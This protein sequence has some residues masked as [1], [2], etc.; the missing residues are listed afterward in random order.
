MIPPLRCNV[1]RMQG[2]ARWG[3]VDRITVIGRRLPVEPGQRGSHGAFDAPYP[4]GGPPFRMAHI[5][6][7]PS[8]NCSENIWYGVAPV[9]QG[10]FFN[11][12]NALVSEVKNSGD[13]AV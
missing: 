12:V 9:L 10:F 1:L 8:P 13:I 11:L 6:T 4:W 5:Y 2:I 7:V 3:R